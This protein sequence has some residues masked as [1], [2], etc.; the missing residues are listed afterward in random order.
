MVTSRSSKSL[1]VPC[2]QWRAGNKLPWKTW[3]QHFIYI[4]AGILVI[5]WLEDP[6]CGDS[7]HL[8]YW[9]ILK[10]RCSRDGGRSHLAATPSHL[11]CQVEIMRGCIVLPFFSV[12]HCLMMINIFFPFW[13]QFV[14][15]DH[16]YYDSFQSQ[17]SGVLFAVSC[18]TIFAEIPDSW[19][20]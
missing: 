20:L 16:V 7:R 6:V 19:R 10:G 11:M 8:I 12:N 13:S 1:S 3:Y 15:C 5:S 18:T 2:S 14:T 9:A 17:M 4:D